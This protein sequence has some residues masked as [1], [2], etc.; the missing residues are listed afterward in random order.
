MSENQYNKFTVASAHCVKE[1]GAPSPTPT[2]NKTRHPPDTQIYPSRRNSTKFQKFFQHK[3]NNKF[4]LFCQ[5]V[6][7]FRETL[8]SGNIHQQKYWL[9]RKNYVIIMFDV[10]AFAFILKSCWHY[11]IYIKMLKTC[12]FMD[13]YI[14]PW[15]SKFPKKYYWKWAHYARI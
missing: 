15:F 9:S 11:V 12:I 7:C 2:V 10:L 3:K 8:F 6:W 14:Q 5:L 4:C 13:L 1:S